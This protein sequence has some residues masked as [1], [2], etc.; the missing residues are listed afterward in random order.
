MSAKRKP[1][2]SVTVTKKPTSVRKKSATDELQSMLFDKP[3][4]VKKASKK[5]DVIQI[6]SSLEES[7]NAFVNANVAKKLIE[8]ES[9]NNKDIVMKAGLNIWCD[10][11]IASSSEPENFVLL[12]KNGSSFSFV[13][14]TKCDITTDKEEALR[15]IG[16]DLNEKNPDSNEYKWVETSRIE[17]N[18]NALKSEKAAKA[19]IAFIQ[20]LEEEGISDAIVPKKRFK[21]SFWNNLHT[22]SKEVEISSD[23]KEQLMIL[24]ET[25]KVSPQAR[26]SKTTSSINDCLSSFMNDEE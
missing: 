8:A 22:I 11:Y 21:P 4:S 3:A 5:M 2:S 25:L 23:P 15:A 12:S 26:Y 9:K 10:R 16:V 20:A 7:F 1:S 24:V 17:I 6:D 19:L 13:F 18:K 14:S